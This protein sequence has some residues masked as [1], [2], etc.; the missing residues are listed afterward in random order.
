MN[1]AFTVFKRNIAELRWFIESL[2]RERA[3]L[4][5]LANC[6]VD[7]DTN[8]HL[9]SWYQ[10]HSAAASTK[11]RFDYTSI[12]ISLYGLLEHFIEGIVTGY[13]R[14]LNALYLTFDEMPDSIK[15]THT[16][17]SIALITRAK[18]GRYKGASTESSIVADL[19]S[20][21]TQSSTYRLNHDAFSHHTSNF[22]IQSIDDILS[23]VGVSGVSQRL[24]SYP[25][26][27]DF[28]A[29]RFRGRDL[30][31][32]PAGETFFH[33]DDLAERRNE[34]AHGP[35]SQLLGY[36]ILL[37]Y[38]DFVEKFGGALFELVRSSL[39]ESLSKLHGEDLG[40]P[41]AV[42]NHHIVC[43][44]LEGTIV[45]VGDILVAWTGD[46]KR[47]VRFGAIESLEVGRQ[48]L[49]RASGDPVAIE[50]GIKV[51]FR[52]KMN[53]SFSRIPKSMWD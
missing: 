27:S 4:A 1:S 12:V 34:V 9:S 48:P 44:R 7:G 49:A 8:S 32:V 24:I 6:E 29:V 46:S 42:H 10:H 37:E 51:P 22:R 17:L 40:R 18:Q 50:V 5:L 3:V 25:P 31:S 47:P 13:T 16:E 38:V 33:I 23:R 19:H 20:C 52:T 28:L 36:D 14:E 35:V 2:E 26:L 15:N 45:D 41:L 21:L 11:R 39:I 43:L 30:P 53:H